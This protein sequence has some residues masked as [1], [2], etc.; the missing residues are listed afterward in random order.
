MKYSAEDSACIILCELMRKG[1][2]TK[3]DKKYILS[4]R[5]RHIKEP[6]KG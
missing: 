5:K 3:S 2:F 4:I 6:C 1:G